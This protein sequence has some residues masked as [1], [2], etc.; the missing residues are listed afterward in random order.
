MS[1]GTPQIRIWDPVTLQ[2]KRRITVRDGAKPV[3]YLNE[4]ECVR[5]EIYANVWQ[6]D[7]I[8]RISPADGRVLG[9]VNLSGL[10][11][12]A[13]RAETR[14]CSTGSRTTY[15]ATGCSS[16]ENFG[17]NSSRSRSF[18][19][20]AGASNAHYRKSW[21]SPILEPANRW[22]APWALSSTA[23]ARGRP[24]R[25]LG[26]RRDIRLFVHH[27]DTESFERVSLPQTSCPSFPSRISEKLGA[28]SEFFTSTGKW[29][30]HIA[31]DVRSLI[32]MMFVAPHE[33]AKTVELIRLQA[34]W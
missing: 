17:Q 31:L 8:V 32:A 6:T 12:E 20:P 21:R 29:P 3:T 10:L 2:E 11:S 1:D 24:R 14:T 9:W 13:D 18:R 23:G 25:I 30:D 34:L 7:R 15:W 19:R 27:P 26:R 33:N 5:G 4:L 22:T 28:S 16:P